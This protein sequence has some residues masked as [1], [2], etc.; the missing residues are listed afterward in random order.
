VQDSLFDISLAAFASIGLPVTLF[1]SF[2]AL[3]ID[4]DGRP[5]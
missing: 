3:G 4:L 1:S 5:S 2:W